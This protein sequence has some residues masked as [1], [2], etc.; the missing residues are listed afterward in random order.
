MARFPD[1]WVLIPHVKGPEKKD[2]QLIVSVSVDEK[3]L[4]TCKHCKH[5]PVD[6]RDNNDD[7]T[8]F[9][10]EFPDGRCPCQ[11]EDA[12]YNWYPPDDW[13]CA[14]GEPKEGRHEDQEADA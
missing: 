13:Y 7:V 2:G 1:G 10:I 9:A 8:G 14:N 12:W 4:V 5:R 11:C 6:N 3:E